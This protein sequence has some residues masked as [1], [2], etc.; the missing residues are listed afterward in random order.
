MTILAR[1]CYSTRPHV[2]HVW[3]MGWRRYLCTGA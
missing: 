3:E 1:Q 2:W